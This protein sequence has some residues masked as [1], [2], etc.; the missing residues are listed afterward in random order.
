MAKKSKQPR[1]E[2]FETF[3]DVLGYTASQLKQ[4][5]PSYVNF[6]SYKKYKVTI[7]EVEESN[8]VYIERLQ[9]MLDKATSF[10]QKSALKSEIKKLQDV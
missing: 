10:R 5:E 1:K 6:L 7:E 9:S 2:E 4:S 3:R 8:E